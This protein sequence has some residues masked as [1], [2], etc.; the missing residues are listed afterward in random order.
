LRIEKFSPLREIADK[1]P[2]YHID[3]K[4]VLY[5][6]AYGKAALKQ[7]ARKI[8]FSFY[9]PLGYLK[10]VWRCFAVVKFFSFG[11]TMSFLFVAPLLL[12]NV[13]AQ[14]ISNGHLKDSLKRTFIRNA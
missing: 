10:M 14:E 12:K 1:T 3:H 2:G 13:I 9:T 8:K 6:D 5:S 11:E 4:G 7:I